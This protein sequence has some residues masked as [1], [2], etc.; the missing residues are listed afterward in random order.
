M[1]RTTKAV[2]AMASLALTISALS[3][4]VYADDSIAVNDTNFPDE[5][6]RNYISQNVDLN[7]NGSLTSSEI[8]S[9]TNLYIYAGDDEYYNSFDGIGYLTNLKYIQIDGCNAES[10]DV[11][12]LAGLLNVSFTN[13]EYLET[14]TFGQHPSLTEL[15]LNN[16]P[17]RSANL[18]GMPSLTSLY[19]IDTSISTLDISSNTGIECL[20]CYDNRFMTYLNIA[21]NPNLMNAYEHGEYREYFNIGMN[22]VGYDI[23]GGMLVVSPDLQLGPDSVSVAIDATNFPDEGF[24]NFVSENYDLNGNGILSA[25]EINAVTEFEIISDYAESDIHDVT[26][27]G[28]FT[29][30]TYLEFWGTAVNTADLSGLHKLESLTLGCNPELTSLTLGQND[31]LSYIYLFRNAISS[32]DFSGCSALSYLSIQEEGLTSI[33]ISHNA[34]LARFGCTCDDIS[35]INISG[36]PLLLRAYNEGT[37]EEHGPFD[38]YDWDFRIWEYDSDNFLSIG[39]NIEIST[40]APAAPVENN[41]DTTPAASE[42]PAGES[43]P[44]APASA[45]APAETTVAPASQDTV[46]PE[47]PASVPAETGSQPT[48][49][50]L[51]ATRSNVSVSYSTHVQ[52]IG[53]QD[54]VRDGVMAGTEGLSYRLEGMTISVESDLDLGIRYCTHVQNVGWMDWSYNGEMSGTEGQSLRL[55]AMKIELTGSAASEYDIYYRVHVQNIGWM[56]WVS[57]GQPAGTEGQSLRLEAMQIKIVPK[58]TSPDIISYNTHVENIGWQGYVTDGV[59]AGTTGQSLRLEGIHIDVTG[60][61]GVGVEYRTHIQNIGWEEGWTADGGFSGTE[62]QSL[63]LEAIEIRLTGENAS[64]YDIYY[65]VHVQNFGWTGWASNG[66]SCGSAGYS[67]RLEGI[68]IMVVPAGSPAPG[69]TANAFYQA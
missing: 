14:I 21:S 55:E 28:Y 31:A 61:E 15:T 52:N 59:M 27:I 9:C 37:Y 60:L 48:G 6:F 10:V 36:N 20:N 34:A 24:R 41:T 69:S 25:G 58:G 68:E 12:G 47:V 66:A 32:V 33:D 16:V 63:R 26:G 23:P 13:D 38:D 46:T 5:D 40:E 64:S 18:S 50:V 65:R 51:G 44:S 39:M 22:A 62:G 56:D 17:V 53:W 3:G 45:E 1:K 7:H 4:M 43:Q 29:E 19:V 42:A 54:S 35:E 49:E 57:N 2:S 11:S 67:Y 30:V 8:S